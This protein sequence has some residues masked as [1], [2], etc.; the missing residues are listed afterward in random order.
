MLWHG[1]PREVLDASRAGKLTF[2]ALPHSWLK[3]SCNGTTLYPL[4]PHR[5]VVQD[6]LDQSKCSW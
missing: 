2:F 5:P 6:V 4:V 1:P 3:F